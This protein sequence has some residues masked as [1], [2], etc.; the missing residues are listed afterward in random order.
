MLLKLLNK[1]NPRL[2]LVVGGFSFLSAGAWV[3]F[4]LGAGL[5][6]IGLSLIILEEVTS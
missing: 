6:S 5:A 3:S 1:V 4:G 2:P